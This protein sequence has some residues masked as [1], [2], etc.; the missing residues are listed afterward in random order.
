ML[1][2][3][4]AP[5]SL[6]EWYVKSAY[7][8][9]VKSEGAPLYE[10][11]ALADLAHVELADWERRGGK[12]AYTRLGNQEDGYNMQIVEIPPGGQL[13]P[14]HHMYDALM[15][16]LSGGGASTIWQEG[17]PKRTIEWQE[18]SLLAIPL[19]AWHQEFN[20]SGTEPCRVVFIS[21]MGR[22]INLYNNI[23]FVFNN[24]YVFSDRYS[25]AMEDF[26]DKEVQWAPRV[27]ET[28]FISDIRALELNPFPERGNRTSIMRMSMAGTSIG[29]HCMGVS[30]GTYVTAHRHGPGA[31]VMVVAGEGYELFFRQGDEK[32][33]TKL[34]ANPYTVVSPKLNEYHQ[35]F[36]TGKGEYRMLAFRGTGIRY[37]HGSSYSAAKTAQSKDPFAYSYKI[38]YEQEDPEIRE[39]YY[40]E[41]EK[42]GIDLRL[43][44]LDQ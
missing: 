37:G 14:E 23:D 12:V 7:Q 26:L 20:R 28:N 34:V 2:E 19:N 5:G 4:K 3:K 1:M 32:N 6:E 16:V 9:F 38:A 31:L 22:V 43:K 8:D 27:L 41:L 11:S 25:Y 42:R 44:P 30:E 10:G 36:N 33:R 17:E 24:K 40:R 13:K 21:N 35:H 15:F 18:G 39:D 29:M